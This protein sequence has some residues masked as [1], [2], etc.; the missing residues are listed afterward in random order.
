MEQY[1]NHGYAL[2]LGIG[3]CA[4][5]QLSLPVT[6]KDTQALRQ[7]LVNPQVCAYPDNDQHLRVLHDEGATQQAIVDGLE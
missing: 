6:V 4:E 2:L 1:F 7:I 5:P 3:Q